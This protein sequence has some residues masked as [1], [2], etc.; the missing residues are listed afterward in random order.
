MS[1]SVLYING[2][3]GND[4]TKKEG[5]YTHITQS[6]LNLRQLG[7]TVVLLNVGQKTDI[8]ELKGDVYFIS[9]RYFRFLLHKIF[10]YTGFTNSIR[11]LFTSIKLHKRYRFQIIHDR[12]G[13][14]SIGGV[15]TSKVLR[16]PLVTEVNGPVIEEKPLFTIPITGFQL[17]IAK[18]LRF[19]CLYNS[20]YIYTVSKMVKS[21]LV[22]WG[23]PKQR[24]FIIPNGANPKYFELIQ[25]KDRLKLNLGWSLENLYVVY[26]GS[27]HVWYG[28]RKFLYAIHRHLLEMSNIK[29]IIIGDGQDMDQLISLRNSLSLTDCVY[30][31][32][33]LSKEEIPTYLAAADILIAPYQNLPIGFFG[34]PI[35]LFEYLISGTALIA[36]DLGQIPEIIEHK[37]TGLLYNSESKDDL[38]EKIILLANNDSLREK[39]GKNGR[40]LALNKYTWKHNAQRIEKIY[41]KALNK[42]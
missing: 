25:D 29:I 1:L 5:Y 31:L 42:S 28:L 15:L 32:G 11:V 19:V 35:K 36:S 4:L 20:S 2:D 33:R 14:Y 40:N 22:D 39:I 8:P 30:F 6:I 17:F 21:Y 24:I 12:F 27:L 9:H 41:K 16:I 26:T 18:Y 10:P 34:S 23:V 37:K 38:V 7:H 3:R 13:L